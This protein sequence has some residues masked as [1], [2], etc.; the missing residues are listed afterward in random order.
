MIREV[1]LVSYLPP[2]MQ[3][4]KEP[5]AALEAEN[6]E[7]ELMWE[8]ADRIFYNRFIS[9]ADQ[10]GLSRFEKMMKISPLDTDTLETR[11]IRVQNRWVNSIP[12]TIR[13]LA[14]KIAELLG[15][16]HN[17]SIYSDFQDCYRMTLVI[18]ST[19]DSLTEEVKYLLSIM[20]PANIV[21]EIIYETVTSQRAI[22]MGIVLEQA[23]II[24]IKQR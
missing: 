11:R 2:F 16:E 14:Y 6:P 19:D 23:D 9:T 22:Y 1:D 13:I 17:F 7:F 20:V 10:Y 21:T 12:Y 24:E 5:V 3:K 15:G 18:Y 8:S 4:Y